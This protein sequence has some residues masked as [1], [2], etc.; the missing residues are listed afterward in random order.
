MS[1]TILVGVIALIGVIIGSITTFYSQHLSNRSKEKIILEEQECLKFDNHSRVFRKISYEIDKYFSK[2]NNLNI[3]QV[4]EAGSIEMYTRNLISQI[5]LLDDSKINGTGIKIYYDILYLLKDIELNCL[6]YQ[7]I[8]N[9][10]TNEDAEI[11]HANGDYIDNRV[12]QLAVLNDEIKMKHTEK[13]ND[14]N[15][16]NK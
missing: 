1:E 16:K 13:T 10:L 4:T 12:G 6:V 9:P 5:E 14:I 11:A 3:H 7:E 15:K 8:T 2:I